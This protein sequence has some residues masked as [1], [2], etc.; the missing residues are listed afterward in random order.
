MSSYYSELPRELLEIIQSKKCILFIGSGISRKCIGNDRKPL[1]NWY[2]FLKSFIDWQKDNQKIKENDYKEMI[3]LL[4]KKKFL[5]V[6][7]ELLELTPTSDFNKFINQ[8]FD[9]KS[10][11]PSYLHELIA[12]IPF[13]GIITSNYDNLIE[14]AYFNIHKRIP[15]I[16][17]H[18]EI[19]EGIDIFENDF[20]IFK[21]HGDIENP[22][23]IIL[24]QRAYAN[25]IYNSINYRDLLENI[26]SNFTVL[27]I[28]Y[29]GMDPDIESILEEISV[30]STKKEINHYMLIKEKSLT[31]IEKRRLYKDK[32]IKVIEYVDYF[33]LHNHID[34]FF[35]DIVKELSEAKCLPQSD[36][37]KK[38]RKSIYVFYDKGD[39]EDGIYLWNYIFKQGAITLSESAQ[40]QQFEIFTRKL[41]EHTAFADYLI[42]FIGKNDLKIDSDFFTAF[43]NAKNLAKKYS[44]HL[45][46]ISLSS[47]N[48]RPIFTKHFSEIPIF[49]VQDKFSEKD[50]QSIKE[51]I[52]MRK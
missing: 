29:G 48:D 41:E 31:N 38:F 49:Y 4:S 28:G 37:P 14:H 39:F 42:I 25:L 18:K 46:I 3:Y 16:I 21:I 40:E 52:S 15:K 50:L 30:G 7:E 8:A 27:F 5:L 11:V 2:E 36:I 20:F 26:L 24:S 19:M 13:R 1:P 47:E 12:I 43:L 6:A 45:I 17:T 35:D 51:Y 9:P 22:K 44:F 32:R 10:I 23:S 34:T 33:G